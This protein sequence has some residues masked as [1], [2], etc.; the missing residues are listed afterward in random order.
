MNRARNKVMSI[1][2]IGGERLEGEQAVH[3]EAIDYFTCMLGQSTA[4]SNN[5][6]HI[7]RQLTL[8]QSN[9]T[10]RPI[11]DI[12]IE[13]AM[14]SMD[15]RKAPGPN[16]FG[17]GFFKCNW[18]I[19]GPDIIAAV[20]SFFSNK[21]LLKAWNSTTISLIPKVAVP[22]TMRN[23]RPIACCNVVYKCITKILVQRFRPYLDS[24]IGGQQ[25]AF[26]PGRHIADNIY[27]G[28]Y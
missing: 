23:F 28:A 4:T 22:D 7:R 8:E 10:V 6:L 27:A 26:I 9:V 1:N 3:R 18:E 20:K 25:S 15:A 14:F 16:G 11:T 13:N 24:I 19:V 17:A 21:R 2:S 12:E 5:P